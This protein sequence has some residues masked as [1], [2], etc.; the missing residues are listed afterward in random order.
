LFLGCAANRPITIQKTVI[1]DDIY[2]HIVEAQNEVTLEIPNGKRLA[3]LEI[4][5]HDRFIATEITELLRELILKTRRTRGFRLVETEEYTLEKL[6]GILEIEMSG[7]VD[8]EE[9]A[10]IGHWLGVDVV[11]LGEISSTNSYNV[12]RIW[13]VEVESRER[14][15]ISRKQL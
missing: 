9:A 5:Y 13:A 11:I 15:A 10:R 12:L 3:I 6:K 2:N 7:Y 4:N 8:D 14:I 1:I